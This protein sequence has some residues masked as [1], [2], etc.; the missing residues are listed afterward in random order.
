[1]WNLVSV[2]LVAV[3][4]WCQLHRGWFP[5]DN[6]V[7]SVDGVSG[8]LDDARR[9][10]GFHQAVAALHDATVSRL[11]LHLRVACQR[12]LDTVGKAV[13]WIGVGVDV[14]WRGVRVATEGDCDQ[15]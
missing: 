4:N 12:V 15:E 1:M 3:I 9:S 6:G 2:L 8:V 11:V 10:V 14:A 7:E 5:V 13:V